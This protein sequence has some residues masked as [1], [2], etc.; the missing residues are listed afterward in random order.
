M[1]KRKHMSRRFECPFCR[2]A[3][4][5]AH[6]DGWRLPMRYTCPDCKSVSETTPLEPITPAAA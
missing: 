6:Q 4:M 5:I 1:D 2:R 3:S